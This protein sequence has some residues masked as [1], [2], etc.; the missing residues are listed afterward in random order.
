MWALVLNKISQAHT[1]INTHINILSLYYF[2]LF[3]LIVDI[4]NEFSKECDAQGG[5][6]A[7]KKERE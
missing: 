6:S 1:T 3:V 2:Y 7:E 4:R 5:F